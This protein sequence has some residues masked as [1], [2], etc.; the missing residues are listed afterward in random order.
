MERG[1]YKVEVRPILARELPLD[2]LRPLGGEQR[3]QWR[4]N[5]NHTARAGFGFGSVLEDDA[6]ALALV[7]LRVVTN[8]LRGL[9]Y[10]QSGVRGV[11]FE[12]A[13]P[14]AERLGRPE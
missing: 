5:G 11:E 2:H 12:V 14:E 4:G 10:R 6:A 13:P 8:A 7:S 9:V 1:E 3:Q